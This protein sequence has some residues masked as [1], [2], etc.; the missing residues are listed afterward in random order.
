M[1][2]SN[3]KALSNSRE[4]APAI[5]SEARDAQM[6]SLAYDLVE[7]RMRDGT[8]TSQETTYFLRLGNQNQKLEKKKLEK[9]IELL[10]LLLQK[11]KRRETRNQV[12]IMAK[13][14][15]LNKGGMIPTRIFCLYF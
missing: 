14:K 2:K 10:V 6:A 15:F 4:F 8:A 1:A 9:Q 11:E 7:Q 12:N 3:G 13:A 5:S